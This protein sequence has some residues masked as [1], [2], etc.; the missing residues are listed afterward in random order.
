MESQS[1][2][3]ILYLRNKLA[4]VTY[5]GDRFKIAVEDNKEIFGATGGDLGESFYKLIS[6]KGIYKTIIEIDKKIQISIN[7]AIRY[8]NLDPSKD[9]I[10]FL[11]GNEMQF[12]AYY[13]IENALFRV[14]SLWDLLAQLYNIYYDIKF[15]IDKLH[16]KRF[17][18]S[19]K[20]KNIIGE[21]IGLY[22][23]QKDN[24][25]CEGEWQGN[26]QYVKNLRNKMTHRNSP[27][28]TVISNFD[29]EFKLPPIYSLKRITED[30]ATASK[31]IDEILNKAQK[32]LKNPFNKK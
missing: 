10:N 9:N 19:K 13:F 25:D 28:I 15:P 11:E 23:E 29:T 30:Y 31:Y 4:S 14:S 3:E 1:N 2:K 7:E 12:L 21:E 18:T 20:H 32:N 8:A 27:N 22:L 17:F 5:K 26:H 24:T 16:Y 6:I